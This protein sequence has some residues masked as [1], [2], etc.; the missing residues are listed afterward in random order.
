[1]VP[2]T[3]GTSSPTSDRYG[4]V[5]IVA[6]NPNDDDR[7]RKVTRKALL[8]ALKLKIKGGKNKGKVRITLGDSDGKLCDSD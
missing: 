2:P 7:V 3:L 1:M 8:F 4:Q 6:R 5:E